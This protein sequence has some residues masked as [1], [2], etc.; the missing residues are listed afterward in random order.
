MK[1]KQPKPSRLDVLLKTKSFDRLLADGDIYDVR[2]A[3]Q[4][5][6]YTPQ[7]VRRLCKEGRLEHFTRGVNKDE[8][9]YY[10][11]PEYL[12]ALFSFPGRGGK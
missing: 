6:G 3:S 10:F 5:S 11:F 1:T 7:H 4:R 8:V 12:T 9:H 2:G